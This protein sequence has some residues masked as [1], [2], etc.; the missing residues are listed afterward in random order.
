MNLITRPATAILLLLSILTAST[1]AQQK[2]PAPP[3]TPPKPAAAFPAPAPTFETLLPADSYAIYVE[4]RGAGQL[5]RSNTVT[6]LLEPILKLAGPPKE[7]KSIVK[8][9]NAH[10][11]QL[12]NSRLCVATAP[13]NKRIPEMIVAVEFASP[14]EAAKFVTPLN[15]FLPTV[16]PTSEPSPTP[17]PNNNGD[18]AAP[19]EN[20]APPAATF[21]LERLGSLIV[22]TQ[23]PW[24]MKQLKPAGSKFFAEDPDFRTVRS[25]FSSEPLFAFIDIKAL[26]KQ[27]AEQLK[28]AEEE[29]QRVEEQAKREQAAA[30]QVEKTSE[31]P[32]SG[33]MTDEDKA[34]AT[35]AGVKTIPVPGTEPAQET[36]TPDPIW[37]SVSDLGSSLFTGASE[38]PD[39]IGLALSFE[40]ESFD[41]R[42]LFVSAPG[43][44]NGVIPFIPKLIPGAALA[45]E[46]PGVFPADTELLITMSLDLPQIY[47]AMSNPVQDPK[48]NGQIAT[49]NKT[50][51]EPPFSAIEKRLKINLNNDL[52]PLL[53][54]EV[55][56][57]LP[58]QGIGLVGAFP[59]IINSAAGVDAGD[60]QAANNAIV[61]AIGVRDKEGLRALMPKLIEGLGF[62]GANSLAQTE[63]RE[64]TELV[65]YANLFS[66]AFVGNFIVLSSNAAATRKIVDSYLK[67]E[68]LSGDIHFK[69]FTRWEPRQLHGQVYISPSLMESLKMWGQQPGMAMTEKTRAFFNR[70]SMAA[71]P[72]TYALS[73]EGFGPLHEL[74]IPKNLVL[75]AVA[76]ISGE[77]NPPPMVQ[78]ERMAMGLVYTIAWAEDEYKNAKGHGNYGTLEQLSEAGLLQKDTLG[79]SGYKFDLTISGDKF[80]VTA[81]PAEYGKSGTLSLFIDQTRVLRGAD[82]SG[83][84]ANASDP[85]IH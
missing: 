35:A 12:M 71:Q 69:N 70:L 45:P 76:G 63:R 42:A 7:F 62:Q 33:G 34:A 66:Y 14:E 46:S 83:A 17:T 44:K 25:R 60:S 84:S 40:G 85:A 65:S 10:S 13:M 8:W 53:G 31:V 29:R 1:L 43:E 24:T 39:A 32:E 18:K 6:D 3:K 26:E 30:K 57:R 64:D 59:T 16:L 79:N 28:R 81:L 20:T 38:W 77:F 37:N 54:S 49:L 51:S 5:V 21:H 67:H 2:R 22:I 78:N 4:V 23:K 55:A 9:L 58:M 47:A 15:E 50:A 11:E 72:I 80:E 48:W 27:D 82:R 36:P 75:M 52:L 19:S 41:L 74:H 61:V 56:V 73:N 68:T